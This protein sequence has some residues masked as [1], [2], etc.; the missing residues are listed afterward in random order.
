MF[1]L[2]FVRKLAVRAR[3][4]Q[5][6]KLSSVIVKSREEYDV[7]ALGESH[8]PAP[9]FVM[10]SF[11]DVDRIDLDAIVDGHTNESATYGEIYERT[12]S[13]AE[14]LRR[15]HNLKVGDVVAIMSPNNLNY[16]PCFFGIALTGA[17]STTIN[18][19]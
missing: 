16:F 4:G 19:L 11:L 9:Q 12:Y 15:L 10:K 14:N 3:R 7:P 18:P 5:S 8:G 17:A 1:R 13:L 2:N 6:Q